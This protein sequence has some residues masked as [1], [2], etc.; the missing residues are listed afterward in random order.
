MRR[1]RRRDVGRDE[2]GRSPLSSTSA[3]PAPAARRLRSIAHDTQMSRDDQI[4][5]MDPSAPSFRRLTSSDE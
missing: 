1:W 2:T 5:E 3:P 4:N